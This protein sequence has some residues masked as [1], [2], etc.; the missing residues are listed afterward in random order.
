MF[1]LPDLT[2]SY[3]ALEPYIDEQTLRVHHNGH[4]A[5]Y[6]K[7]L[8]EILTGHQE[9]LDMDIDELL[10][11]LNQIVPE[12]IRQKVRN[13]AGGHGNHSLFWII[14][15]PPKDQ[16][17]STDLLEEINKNFGSFEVFKDKFTQTAK[18]IFGSGY[19]WLVVDGDRKSLEVT[20]TANQDSP[21]TLGHTPIMG[22]DVWEHAYYLKY[23]N[24]R[25][26]YI[27]NWWN[28][29]NWDQVENNYK[30]AKE[31]LNII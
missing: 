20:A 28:V 6:V 26:D 17:P 27:S 25:P 13:S 15:G 22:I 10:K 5:T 18:D 21:L 1:T 23:K 9:L 3:D 14:I 29:I 19:A 24:K 2:Y 30:K 7:N 8:N 4:H 16:D 11:K 31:G 12:D